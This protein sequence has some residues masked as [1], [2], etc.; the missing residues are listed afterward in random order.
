MMILQHE[1]T[2][3]KAMLE[4][5]KTFPNGCNFRLR[6]MKDGSKWIEYGCYCLVNLLTGNQRL[7]REFLENV[8]PIEHLT[9]I[10]HGNYNRRRVDNL[11]SPEIISELL[12][13]KPCF[14]CGGFIFEI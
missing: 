9:N 7:L 10:L 11:V 13:R 6:I 12:I 4:G 8:P 2:L 3:D 14:C 1:V 5:F